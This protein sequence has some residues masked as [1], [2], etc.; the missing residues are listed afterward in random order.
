LPRSCGGERGGEGEWGGER[1][2][3]GEKKLAEFEVLAGD[4]GL[5]DEEALLKF[6][7]T[8]SADDAALKNG[9]R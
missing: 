5:S 9:L 4:R 3:G 7:Y 8:G 6:V 2:G 1:C